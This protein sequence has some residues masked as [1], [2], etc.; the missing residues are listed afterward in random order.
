MV[1]GIIIVMLASLYFIT[2]EGKAE[3]SGGFLFIFGFIP[4]GFA[5]GPYSEYIMVFLIILALAI[6]VL[7]FLLR[8]FAKT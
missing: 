7:S 5:F 6:M 4:I 1:L 3:V 2:T 8:K